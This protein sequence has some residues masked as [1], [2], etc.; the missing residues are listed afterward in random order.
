[1]LDLD[2]MLRYVPFAALHDGSHYLVENFSVAM[3]TEAARDKLS[4]A[5][6]ADWSVWGLGVTKG[7]ADYE[8]LPYANVELN[9]IAGQKG[10]LAVSKV[11]AGFGAVHRKA[12]SARHWPRPF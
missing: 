12:F 6:K 9:G 2:D 8:A 5:P 7:G 11:Q 3:V 10:I 1:M 4:R